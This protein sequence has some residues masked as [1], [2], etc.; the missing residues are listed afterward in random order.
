MSTDGS[1]WNN[2]T[3]VPAAAVSAK[4]LDVSF[5]GSRFVALLSNT[6]PAD[7]NSRLVMYSADGTNW[8][9]PATTAISPIPTNQT[10]VVANSNN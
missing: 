7:P 3:T 8:T 9:M 1:N 5:N 6:L 2:A 10:Y 4:F